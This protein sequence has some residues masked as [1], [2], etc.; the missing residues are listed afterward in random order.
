MITAKPV[1]LVLDGQLG[2]IPSSKLG[3]RSALK[4]LTGQTEQTG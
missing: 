3:N 1:A 2:V 4:G